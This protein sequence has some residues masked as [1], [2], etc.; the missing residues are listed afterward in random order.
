MEILANGKLAGPDYF[1]LVGYFVLMLGIGAYFYRYMKG[2]K[3]YFSGNNKIP[4][5]LSG[6][7]FYMSCFSA[8]GFIAYSELAFKYGLVAVTIWWFCVPS[9]VLSII[10]LAKKWRRMRIDSPVE[11]LE[12][13]YSPLVRQVFAWQGLPVRL[14]DDALKLVAIGMF[15][16]KAFNIDVMNA[17]LFSGLIMLSYTM[18]GGLW[19]VV[20][21]DFVQ[22]V[23]MAVAMIVLIPL[24]LN[25]A[26]G[27]SVF[28][29]NSP[30][31]FFKITSPEYDWLYITV[32]VLLFFLSYSSVNWGLIQRYYCVPRE[33]D[34][35]KLGVLVMVLQIIGPPMMLF[36][37]M[38]ARHFMPEADAANIYPL[39]CLRL[40]PVGMIGLMIAAMFSATMSMLSS[41]YNAAASVLTND[42]YKRVIRPGASSKELVLVGRLMTCLVGFVAIGIAYFLMKN[43]SENGGD[44]LF[45]NMMKLFSVATAPV[46]IPMMFGI[47]FKKINN[48]AAVISFF[49]GITS[50]LTIFFTCPDEVDILGKAVKSEN[51]MLLTTTTVTALAILIIS[52]LMPSGKEE[53]GRVE[54]FLTRLDTPIGEL[55]EDNRPDA[56][57]TKVFSP[58]LIVGYSVVFIA[59]LMAVTLPYIKDQPIAFKV[60]LI[61]SLGLFVLGLAMVFLSKKSNKG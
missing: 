38:A 48:K 35:Y 49:A 58:F 22:F 27:F 36:P 31:G 26:G 11:Y 3:D 2:M 19:A 40:L 61:L 5:W 39:L 14:I 24:S 53:L 30:E 59:F 46:A 1:I 4:W 34:V 10:L 16:S 13:R 45:R 33:K 32:G 6:V 28:F 51:L 21:T 54:E 20:V 17:M 55:E 52:R 57:G 15:V 18:M 47:L 7:S 37:A 12:T 50:G 23:I 29:S 41:D 43:S 60:N 44:N 56:P 42:I 8:F 25:A 9:L